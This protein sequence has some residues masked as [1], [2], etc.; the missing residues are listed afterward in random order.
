[1]VPDMI[2]VYHLQKNKGTGVYALTWNRQIIA[3][4]LIP[5]EGWELKSQKLS[6]ELRGALALI[7]TEKQRKMVSGDRFE[8]TLGHEEHSPVLIVQQGPTCNI[9]TSL[10]CVSQLFRT[11]KNWLFS[12]QWK[13]IFGPDSQIKTLNKRHFTIIATLIQHSKNNNQMTGCAS[14]VD[15]WTLQCRYYTSGKQRPLLLGG[16][17]WA[18]ALVRSCCS[19][20]NSRQHQNTARST[21]FLLHLIIFMNAVV[22][23]GLSF[24]REDSTVQLLLHLYSDCIRHLKCNYSP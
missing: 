9:L 19:S 16:P 15:L 20:K 17:H 22:L 14:P 6:E 1:M 10:F 24:E 2:A 3:K 23:K 4:T 21:W 5:I 7:D 12:L 13:H 11:S 18:P 8:I